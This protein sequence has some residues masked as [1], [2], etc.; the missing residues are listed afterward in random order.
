MN[1]EHQEAEETKTPA[2]EQVNE[3]IEAT[4]ATEETPGEAGESEEQPEPEPPKTTFEELGLK[5][6]LLKAIQEMGFEHPSDVQ[7]ATI[8]V[9]LTGKDLVVQ[10]RTGTGKTGAFG[11]PLVQQLVDVERNEVQ[12]LAL[13]P[14]RELAIQ[15]A[16]EIGR[17]AVGSG[18]K[19][20]PVYG[21]AA[22]GPQVRALEEGVHI[23]AGTP[24]RVLDHIRR[25]NLRTKQIQVLILDEGDEM[26]SM[27]FQEEIN[28]IIERLPKERQTLLFS[29]TI[30]DEI[31]A[32]VKRHLTEPERL[33]LSEDYISVREIDHLYYLVSGG[34]RPR[35]LLK[36]LEYENPELALIF[37]NTRDDT[38][39]V[40]MVLQKA[41]F[42]AE[43][44]SSDLSQ[45]E[46]ERVMGHMRKGDLQF[47]VATEVAARG[48][49]LSDLSHV[50]N[51]TFPESAD[52][53]VHR[54]GRTGRAGKHGV[55]ISLVSPREI[56]S[57]Y[58][59]KLI[60]KIEPEERHLPSSE[61]MASSREGERYTS[62]LSR[63][64]NMLP[65]EEMR[66]LA[67]RVWSTSDG[68]RVMAMALAQVL[69]APQE[70][71]FKPPPAPDRPKRERTPPRREYSDDRPRRGRDDRPR[72]GRDDRPRRG[73]RD[74]RPRR[75]GRDDRP[76]RGRDDRPRRDDRSGGRRDRPGRHDE[77]PGPRTRRRSR[78]GEDAPPRDNQRSFTTPDGD[79]EIWEVMDTPSRSRGGISGDEVRLYFNVGRRQGLRSSTELA[80]H[81]QQETDLPREDLGRIQLRDTHCYVQVAASQEEKLIEALSGKQFLDRE[82]RVERARR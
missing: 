64:E 50:I 44:I 13:A 7:A 73:G 37:C 11:I 18:L 41:G 1:D 66:S 19:I 38:S 29:A 45:A 65:S 68:E 53:Y 30:P 72:R 49:D 15:V 36:V 6:E 76:R 62:L 71:M 2:E 42:K 23:V 28:N 3:E 22:M 40:A 54:T 34:D 24:G 81:I 80:R 57:F 46:R 43:G 60:H 51:Y 5:P 14:T 21:G 82:L 67:R 8:P 16:E 79:V 12:A 9:A 26:L 4:E 77:R 70:V 74:D 59:L 39:Y 55:A 35:D 63:Y 48:I 52:M 25:G 17:L 10:S 20:L 47:L 33:L 61:E 78:G 32:M 56:G 27:G 75:G 58:Y 31:K 69:E